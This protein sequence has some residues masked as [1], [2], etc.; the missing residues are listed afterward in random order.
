[1]V[2]SSGA[3][4]DVALAQHRRRVPRR[5]VDVAR[6]DDPVRDAIRADLADILAYAGRP[7]EAESIAR[8]I[9]DKDDGS[10]LEG[11]VFN[12]LIH[13]L[14]TQG[15]WRD[16]VDLAGVASQRAT[17]EP[18]LRARILADSALARI[19][20]GDLS[21]AE[22]EATEALCMAEE[23]GD[24]AAAWNALG[25]LSAVADKRGRFHEGVELARE[26]S[27]TSQSGPVPMTRGVIR[28]WR[29]EWRWCL[30]IGFTSPSKRCNRDVSWENDWG[31]S[32]ICRSTTR[33]SCFRCCFWVSGRGR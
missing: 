1:M 3:G 14:F 23:A 24:L 19:W 22:V 27:G 25:N 26:R 31:R 30:Q 10:A 29:S 5:A 15:R 18:G 7:L 33:W 11:R 9:L 16:M 6:T 32:G 20:T 17:I 28:T 2:P 4:D 12:T 8:A 13:A 21:G